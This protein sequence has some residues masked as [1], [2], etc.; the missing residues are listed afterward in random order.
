[1]SQI[2]IEP[3]EFNEVIEEIKKDKKDIKKEY[4]SN[5]YKNN[6]ED[7][8]NKLRVKET[9]TICNKQTRHQNIKIHQKSNKCRLFLIKNNENDTPINKKLFNKF[10]EFI[11]NVDI[12]E[13]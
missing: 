7:F 10:C 12:N 1:M 8:L 2:I 11:K 3:I 5:Y 4:N 9:C 6:K 13:E